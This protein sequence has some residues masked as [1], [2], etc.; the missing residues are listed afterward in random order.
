[1]KKLLLFTTMAV[2]LVVTALTFS[3]KAHADVQLDNSLFNGA[4][5]YSWSV[6]NQSDALSVVSYYQYVYYDAQNWQDHGNVS[7][8]SD[9]PVLNSMNYTFHTL[10]VPYYYSLLIPNYSITTGFTLVSNTVNTSINLVVGVL[11]NDNSFEQFTT[12]G[13]ITY[14]PID[15]KEVKAIGF[16]NDTENLYSVTIFTSENDKLNSNLYYQ[17]YN[18]GYQN[19]VIAGQQDSENYYNSIIA[20]KDATISD[21]QN[22][23]NSSDHIGFTFYDLLNNIFKFPVKAIH[24]IFY[25]EEPI[26]DSVT[27]EP[28]VDSFGNVQYESTTPISLFGV[29]IIGVVVGVVSIGLC[30]TIIAIVKKVWK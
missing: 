4:N 7:I 11:Y 26:I 15:Q 19:G 16:L 1:M 23:L 24:R 25:N 10:Q 29:S 18:E 13:Y 12:N 28:V 8:V 14:F 20:G 21:L 6:N 30:I 9:K 5:I 17:G 27:G 22:Q 3:L 2:A